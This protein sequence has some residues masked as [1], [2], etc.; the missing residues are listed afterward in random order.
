MVPGAVPRQRRGRQVRKAMSI[1]APPQNIALQLTRARSAQ[2]VRAAR[3]FV[4][5]RAGV[6]NGPSQLNAVFDGR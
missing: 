4:P 1:S 6:I 2:Q 3:H 5:H